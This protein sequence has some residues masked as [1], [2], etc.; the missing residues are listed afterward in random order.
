M[1]FL[2]FL[3]FFLS[4]QVF[5]QEVLSPIGAINRGKKKMGQLKTTPSVDSTYIYSF[6]TLSLPFLDEFSRSKFPTMNAQP[7]DPNVSEQKYYHLTDMADVPLSNSKKF[8]TIPTKRYVT[9]AGTT[10]E[11]ELPLIS[12]KIANFQYFP[13]QYNVTQVYPPY[14]VYDTLDYVNAMDTILISNPDLLQDSITVFF[15]HISDPNVL[16]TDNF[17]YHNYTFAKNPWT[18]GV[19]T[20]D[21]V[22]QHGYPYAINTTQ[23][24]V[25]D[26][27]TSKT[28]D[29]STTVPAD[30]IYLS[31]LY[32]FEG[33]SDPAET[34]DSIV[35][36]FYNQAS[37]H[38]DWIWSKR[39]EPVSD[40]KLAHL[41]IT[42]A[43]YLTDG[44][45]FRFKNYGG[46]SGLLDIV[47]I[48][49]V[50]LRANSGYQDTLF[51]DFAFVYPVSSLIDTYTQVPYEHWLSSPTHMNPKVNVV[52][53]NGSNIT[54]N[55]MNGT[56]D[57]F[58]NSVLEG[59]FTM[60]A[61]DLS[62]GNI[63]YAPRTTYDSEHDFTNGYVFSSTTDSI[64][65]FDI[66]G[67]VSAQYPNL[68][69]NDSSFTTQVFE[70]V[71]AYDDGS[72]EQAYG[73]SQ[74]QGRM[75][76][77]FSPYKADTL[78]GVR[79]YFAPTVHDWSN[80]LFLLTVW[81]DN[82]GVPGTIIYEDDF[83]NT[84][85]PIYEDERG[86]FTDYLFPSRIPMAA[87]SFYVGTRQVDP[88]PLNVGFDRNNPQSNKL[89][90]SINGG[91]TWTASSM[92][93]IPMVR[94]L[95]QT[96]NNVTLNVAEQVEEQVNWSV[97][98]NPTNGIATISWNNSFD[99]PGATIIDAQ[100]RAIA[101]LDAEERTIDL[102]DKMPGIYFVK[103][104]NSNLTLKI[105]R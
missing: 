55:N 33:F 96:L 98:P 59:S 82:G 30:S 70:N 54:E 52:V 83:F 47:N 45:R 16:W 75:A 50:H 84:R 79:I 65:T 32:Q 34:N 25:A 97:Y 77:K 76:V 69:L 43:A 3:F 86:K 104:S 13:I 102:T 31:F 39:G 71:Y 61:Q 58:Y 22:D 14:N 24:G 87:N 9:S 74:A 85:T 48:D 67:H 49:Y 1:K 28:I 101:T 8:S 64:K 40:F 21:G 95:F 93:G 38:W 62:G 2:T 10:T 105:L 7:G 66:V 44:F 19:A 11:S 36:E 12:I 37:D 42:D 78:M 56:V 60:I 80:K 53:R 94:P 73:I 81:A 17:A 88:Q 92:Q 90:Y 100:G 35:L 4:L 20:F 18:L 6:D 41:R 15:A 91:L 63:N 27:L 29:L 68:S 51:K 72:A 103:L 23:E 89:F 46:L 26:Y 99:F 5:A 57:V